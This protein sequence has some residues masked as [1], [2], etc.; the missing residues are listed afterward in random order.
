[1]TI[2]CKKENTERNN[3]DLTVLQ[4]LLRFC[5]LK[6]APSECLRKQRKKKKKSKAKVLSPQLHGS[7]TDQTFMRVTEEPGL[8]RTEASSSKS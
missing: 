8:P 1:M 2:I 5:C 4:G 3:N 7:P 6:M